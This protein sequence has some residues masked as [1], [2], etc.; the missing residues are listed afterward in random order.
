MRKILCLVVLA[1]VASASTAIADSAAVV[2]K[3]FGLIGTWASYCTANADRTKPG[4]RIVFGDPPDGAPTFTTVSAAD[5]VTTTVRSMVLEAAGIGPGQVRLQLR[6]IGGDR[7]GGP[8]PDPTTNTFEQVIEKVDGSGI[9]LVGVD[10][11]FI[12]KC[13]E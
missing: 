2:I 12:Q 9:R 4:L 6:I 13:P 7:D 1:S 3:S 8:L 10:P 11:R 5:A